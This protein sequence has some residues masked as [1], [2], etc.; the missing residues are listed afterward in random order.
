M[1]KHTTTDNY[2]GTNT[3]MARFTKILEGDDSD[4]LADITV[5]NS[6]ILPRHVEIIQEVADEHNVIIVLRPTDPT[7][8]AI[9]AQMEHGASYSTKS[10]DIHSK[11]S[12]WGP[13][14]GFVPLDPFL[15]KK[16]VE[17]L[18]DME[19]SQEDK[20][21]LAPNPDI[22][23]AEAE[24]LRKARDRDNL[25]DPLSATHRGKPTGITETHLQITDDLLQRGVDA[26][27]YDV[28]ETEAKCAGQP[29]TLLRIRGNPDLQAKAPPF[30]ALK[31]PVTQLYSVYWVHEHADP[32]ALVPVYVWAYTENHKVRPVTG[33]YDL[34]MVTPHIDSIDVP[35][36]KSVSHVKSYAVA[37]GSSTMTEGVHD[38]LQELISKVGVE[39]RHG[40]E[41]FNSGF[42]Q[43]LDHKLAMIAPR[44]SRLKSGVLDA[45]SSISFY[46]V[47]MALLGYLPLPNIR[48]L[49]VDSEFGGTSKA[50]YTDTQYE[51]NDPMYFFL[52]NSDLRRTS[53]L[54][55]MD[56]VEKKRIGPPV[57]E[58]VPGHEDA[59]RRRVIEEGLGKGAGLRYNYAHLFL[60]GIVCRMARQFKV[61]RNGK[62]AGDVTPP[63]QL[64]SFIEKSLSCYNRLKTPT[65][66]PAVK[67]DCDGLFAQIE[68][69]FTV[70]ERAM[71]DEYLSLGQELKQEIEK[72]TAKAQ[73]MRAILNG[74]GGL[75]DDLS[76]PLERDDEDYDD[77][78]ISVHD[79]LD[80]DL[81]ND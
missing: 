79:L 74:P 32:P 37:G 46:L 72:Q 26:G 66:D 63:E 71:L 13:M 11:S 14:A 10:V 23:A 39:I 58:V 67:L 21:K 59:I 30:C 5:A 3:K 55:N 77:D 8:T 2:L 78:E 1:S 18:L 24:H 38:I 64:D 43:K 31:D 51:V 7:S 27:R 73:R 33:D 45:K 25:L 19:I 28:S 47:K 20:A 81:L 16:L 54:E 40:P 6:G 36:I 75:G 15:S 29:G 65:P 56:L 53:G 76:V 17:K 49:D 4:H 22:L 41:Q 34:W 57:D 69:A 70:E 48:Y 68:T 35:N 52:V 60:R 12:N 61:E 50:E 80:D 44:T 9:L 42:T 62:G